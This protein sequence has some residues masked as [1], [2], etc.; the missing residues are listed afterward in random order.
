MLF[1][2][3]FFIIYSKSPFVICLR[4]IFSVAGLGS[5]IHFLGRVWLIYTLIIM[6]LGGIIIV[7][8]Y[9]STVNNNF[10]VYI[11]YLRPVV[12]SVVFRGGV[13]YTVQPET[14]LSQS[15]AAVWIFPVARAYNYVTFLA[16]TILLSLFIIVKMVQIEQGPLKV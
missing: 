10:K 16:F 6:F 5:L 13:V 15:Q 7:F 9:T 3:L 14:F 4:L 8:V 11:S 2:A 1:I 12:C